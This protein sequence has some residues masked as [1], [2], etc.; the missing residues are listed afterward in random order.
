MSTPAVAN[1]GESPPPP[2]CSARGTQLRAC[3]GAMSG[4]GCAHAPHVIPSGMPRRRA[5]RRS[6]CRRRT[7]PIPLPS[8]SAHPRSEQPHSKR[9]SSNDADAAL[10]AEVKEALGRRRRARPHVLRAR[11]KERVVEERVVAVHLG[12]VDADRARRNNGALPRWQRIAHHPHGNTNA[13][14]RNTRTHTY[15][16]THTQK[17][18]PHM[19]TQ[20]HMHTHAHTHTRTHTH[21]H[22]HKH[23]HTHTNRRTCTASGYPVTPIAPISPSRRSSSSAGSVSR[24][25]TSTLGANSGS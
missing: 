8:H 7:R 20:T 6:H 18:P 23:T 3:S 22:T 13:R 11:V 24:T 2:T 4:C 12:R 14:M 16:P 17:K 9:R 10:R 1:A 21:T 19:H 15:T 5:L 25:T